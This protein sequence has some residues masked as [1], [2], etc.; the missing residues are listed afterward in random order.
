VDRLFVVGGDAPEP[1]G[2]F[3]DAAALLTAIGELGHD[4]AQ[5]GIG[6][7]PE[8]HAAI[9]SIDLERALAAK[10]PFADHVITQMCFDPKVTVDWARGVRQRHPQLDVIVG[11]P[12]PVSAQKLMRI[13]A[14]LGLGQSARFLRKQQSAVWRLLAPG[15]YRPDRLVNGLSR[16]LGGDAPA[17]AGFHVFTFNELERAEAWRQSVLARKG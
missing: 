16:E 2:E 15:G 6:G 12:A 5:V 14:G 11:L 1:A 7:Y 10:A 4:F 9:P 13:S 3:G 8:G 17:I